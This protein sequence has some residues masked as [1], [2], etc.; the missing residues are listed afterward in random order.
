[1]AALTHPHP[2]TCGKGIFVVGI[3]EVEV[4]TPDWMTL[5]LFSQAARKT[6]GC[7]MTI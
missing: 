2:A 4:H 3:Y 6:V 5:V 7:C 1:M